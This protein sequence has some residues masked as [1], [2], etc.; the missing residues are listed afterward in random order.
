MAVNDRH[1]PVVALQVTVEL[2]NQEVV[3][4]QLVLKRDVV[5]ELI[6]DRRHELVWLALA[7]ALQ[8]VGRVAIPVCVEIILVDIREVLD[9]VEELLS[10]AHL[11]ENV[12]LE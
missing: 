1:N 10:L 9:S 3:P 7:K 2:S 12:F 5:F 8:N 6:V 11:S 4:H